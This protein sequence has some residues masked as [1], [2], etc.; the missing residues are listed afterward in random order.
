MRRLFGVAVFLV[1]VVGLFVI[2]QLSPSKLASAHRAAV[3]SSVDD[4][5]RHQTQ[6]LA[7]IPAWRNVYQ[8]A[9]PCGVPPPAP[10][11]VQFRT[12]V[13]GKT[14]RFTVT[15][16]SD[17]K[18]TRDLGEAARALNVD[19]NLIGNLVGGLR[20]VGRTGIYQHD[21]QLRIPGGPNYGI[22]FVSPSCPQARQYEEG[23]LPGAAHGP[24]VD[25]VALG[26]GW[27]YYS[28]ND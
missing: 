10:G 22:V 28:E 8:H 21:D 23:S 5:H 25:L 4:F 3:A 2:Y 7:L 9:D 1:L 24:F 17:D 19:Q 15:V 27:Y 18:V 6:Y 12:F 13:I 16:G 14:A 20:S 26:E 11:L